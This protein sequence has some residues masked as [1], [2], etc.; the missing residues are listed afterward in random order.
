MSTLPEWSPA[1]A[2][3]VIATSPLT[4]PPLLPVNMLSAPLGPLREAPVNTEAFPLVAPL[5]KAGPV[6]IESFP[7]FDF[8]ALPVL[9][10]TAPPPAAVLAE[11][12]LPAERVRSPP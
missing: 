12:V 8:C 5:K 1:D 7:E 6:A 9:I 4:S 10:D 11:S 3:V 2:P